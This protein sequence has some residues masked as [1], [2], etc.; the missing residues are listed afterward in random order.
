MILCLK[1]VDS[2]TENER[3]F[4]SLAEVAEFLKGQREEDFE[5]VVL[6]FD[7]GSSIPESTYAAVLAY[8]EF[9]DGME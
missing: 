2:T 7:D 8:C 6:E 3:E 1:F 4:K 5:Y 9:W